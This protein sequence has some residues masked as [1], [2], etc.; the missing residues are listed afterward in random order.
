[1]GTDCYATTIRFS[2]SKPVD[3]SI[4]LYDINGKA[5]WKKQMSVNETI[6]GINSVRWEGVNE[7]GMEVSNGVYF[8]KVV[9]E[10][11]TIIKKLSVIK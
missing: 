6:A 4:M 8:L 5:V 11:K 2:L 3:V 1:M 7:L 9:A 10:N